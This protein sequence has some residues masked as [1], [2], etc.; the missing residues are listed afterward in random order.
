MVSYLQF[1]PNRCLSSL[2]RSFKGVPLA[3]D[4][5]KIIGQH[6]DIFDDQ[7]YIHLN[8]EASF[9]IFKPQ[10]RQMLMVSVFTCT[11]MSCFNIH[12]DI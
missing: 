7:G 2:S 12:I 10:E 3:Y 8:V 9:V 11:F 5:I 4:G 6:G 1:T